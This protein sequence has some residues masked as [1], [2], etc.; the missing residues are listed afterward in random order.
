MALEWAQKQPMAVLAVAAL[1]CLAG[2]AALARLPVQLLPDIES[3]TITIWTG[4]PGAAAADVER[5]ITEPQESV[6]QGLE[7]LE[8]IVANANFGGSWIELSF[9]AGTNLDPVFVEVIGRLQRVSTLP[10]DA[11]APVV[12]RGGQ[13]PERTLIY[14]FVQLLPGTTGP[15]ERYQELIQRSVVPRLEKI[16]GVAGAR[17][18]AGPGTELRID[19]DAARAAAL[20]IE[21]ATLARQ[22]SQLDDV[23]AGSAEIG[24]TN[25]TLRM[26]GR[27]DPAQIDELPVGRIDDRVVRLSEIG[28]A[29]FTR[30]DRTGLSYQN[31]NP[32]LTLQLFRRPGSNVLDTLDALDAEVESLRAD[33]LS[34]AGLDI[35][36][37]FEPGIFI[38][39]AIA[40]LGGNLGL[41]L[42][43][44]LA[45]LWLFLRDLRATAL[46]A[47]AVPVSLLAT[48]LALAALGRSLN[49]ISIAG[50]AFAVGMVMDAAIVVVESALARRSAGLDAADAV[51]EGTR[52][53]AGALTAATV[54][55]VAVF[56]PVL[57]LED[58]AGQIFA[59]LALTIAIAVLV[60]LA[61]ALWVTPA[62]LP[63]W[64][65]SAPANGLAAQLWPRLAVRVAAASAS[66]RRAAGVALALVVLPLLLA[67]QL[68]PQ[69][70][71]L[72]T[73][74]RAALDS[75]L[76][77][78][79]GIGFERL[80]A[81][82]AKPLIER[83][84]PYMDGT[85]EPRL[86]NYYILAWN[87]GATLGVRVVDNARIGEMETLLNEELLVGLPDLRARAR[88]GEL[89]GGIGGSSRAVWINLRDADGDSLRAAAS[90]AETMLHE[91]LP[92]A[93]I[94]MFPSSAA[95]GAEIAVLPRDARLTER[96]LDRTWLA[97]A[98][99]VL[100]DGRFLGEHFDGQRRVPMRLR[101]PHWEDLDELAA[102][103]L[104]TPRGSV[105]LGELAELSILR[106][107]SELRRVDFAR[108]VT[109]SV[110][111]P[112]HIALEEA[113][114]I[115]R[116]EVLPALQ[117][118]LP[119]G[120][121]VVLGGSAGRL[122]ALT[123]ALLGNLLLAIAALALILLLLLRSAWDTA[124]VLATL[125]LA[126]LGGVLGLRLLGLFTI[127]PLDLLTMIGFV[128]LLAMVVS[129]GV[130]LVGET[131]AAQGRGLDLDA[132]ITQSLRE[133]LRP[134][135]LGA[136]T[137]VMG[138]LP[139][140]I[141]PGPAA[142]IYRGLA[143]VTCG[144][145]LLSLL[146]VVFLV[147]ALLRL[148]PALAALRVG[149]PTPIVVEGA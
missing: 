131:R 4:W 28:R 9:A 91:K 44:A 30:P 22:L 16:P 129:N 7:G 99:R 77:T 109:V 57:L 6:M 23:S 102:T 86:L 90:T 19:I 130:L 63:R 17:L 42:L 47:V 13:G 11:Q 97:D 126:A 59:D 81:E 75:F 133:R 117:A 83:L 66:P 33:L 79:P 135:T 113:L 10:R 39:R 12:N 140:A 1:V 65:K 112:E 26:R 127:Q 56:M 144:G 54:T 41:G 43:A 73:V 18:N 124:V 36:K 149:A 2:L 132:A 31:G 27:F 64:L 114:A 35:Q 62:L 94:Q 98:L 123:H 61:V 49:M 119:R 85:A 111:P 93:R 146:L 52:R 89:F 122:Q 139:L 78:P 38:R 115:L 142:S 136:L 116:A 106:T 48:T 134:L 138:A 76:Q 3:P 120:A 95:V 108:A 51:A 110:D 128:M 118:Q 69:R 60:S 25:H 21:L 8:G 37:S 141:S 101:G 92:G 24:R 96:G 20:G 87:G 5:G 14:Y 143:A 29:E 67:W 147:P 50:L 71:F 84:R 103:P 137:G 100:G 80:D 34:P 68:A 74:K 82:V 88:E 148:G 107:P 53:V 145:V 40:F 105:S 32:A 46:I 125:P 121:S 72:P 45:M 70:D 104:A 55:T 15:V 58:V